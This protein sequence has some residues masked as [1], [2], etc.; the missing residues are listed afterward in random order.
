MIGTRADKTPAFDLAG[1][2]LQSR[3][4]QAVD[5]DVGCLPRS[6][7]RARLNILYVSGNP[8]SLLHAIV[9]NL[10]QHHHAVVS[11]L[12]ICI[13]ESGIKGVCIILWTNHHC[14]GHAVFHLRRSRS[15]H[16]GMIPMRAGQMVCRDF[17][18]ILPCPILS[19]TA[20]GLQV[21][22]VLLQSLAVGIRIV[23]FGNDQIQ[24]I[25]PAGIHM[26]SMRVN[27]GVV[28]VV[29]N[30]EFVSDVLDDVIRVRRGNAVRPFKLGEPRA[31]R[32]VELVFEIDLEQIVRLINKRGT[33]DQFKAWQPVARVT[34]IVL[35]RV[36]TIGPRPDVRIVNRL[37]LR[38]DGS[39]DTGHSELRVKTDVEISAGGHK[40]L[41]LGKRTDGDSVDEQLGGGKIFQG[42]GNGVLTRDQDRRIDFK[43]HGMEVVIRVGVVFHDDFAVGRNRKCAIRFTLHNGS[44]H[45]H[46]P[47]DWCLLGQRQVERNT[48]V[49]VTDQR[50]GVEIIPKDRTSS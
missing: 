45:A 16:V 30:V 27:V 26:Q 35:R 24:H 28:A 20:I 21:G 31:F 43:L 39:R 49:P 25:F 37:S 9:G 12:R 19:V 18:G 2:Q 13:P 8:G 5:R 14:A 48:L 1:N 4:I 38:I 10:L 23:V 32:L 11:F 46:L 33:G 42:H 40:V 36:D 34:R 44:R 41:R 17:V 50:P 29:R 47:D 7:C 22:N 15:V 3:L 6:I